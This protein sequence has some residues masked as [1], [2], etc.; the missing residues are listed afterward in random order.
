MHKTKTV[1]DIKPNVLWEDGGAAKVIN[2]FTK[3]ER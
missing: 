3:E 1:T 2:S